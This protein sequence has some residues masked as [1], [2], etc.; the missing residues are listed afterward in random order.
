M[1][2][3]VYASLHETATFP[4]TPAL[5]ARA[6]LY[7]S[8]DFDLSQIGDNWLFAAQTLSGG[9]GQFG[10]H[11]TPVNGSS[12]FQNR[13]IL[14][15]PGR[16]PSQT[17]IPVREWACIEWQVS[18]GAAR[19]DLRV[20]LNGAELTDVTMTNVPL[21]TIEEFWFGLY[22][23]FAPGA[24]DAWYDEIAI[25]NKPIGCDK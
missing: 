12:V 1:T 6:F 8:T 22:P 18:Q 17:R 11:L 19:G 21:I 25:D 2:L 5:Y 23:E 14:A 4:I 15:T 7:I 9:A 13:D 20:W 3:E 16:L 24:T 10:V